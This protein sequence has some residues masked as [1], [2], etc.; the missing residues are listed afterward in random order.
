MKDAVTKRILSIS[1]LVVVTTLGLTSYATLALA[2]GQG[3]VGGDTGSGQG[4]VGG[5]TGS[6]QGQGSVGGDTS[7]VTGSE[8]LINPLSGITSVNDLLVAILNVLIIIATPIIVIFII[9]AGFKYVTARGNASQIEEAHKALTYA[10]IGGVL[11][12]G[13]VAISAIVSDLVNAFR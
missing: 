11:I 3:S 12:I 1:L 5:D 7:S 8:S 13:A 6:G 4:S 9:L 10:I 2:E